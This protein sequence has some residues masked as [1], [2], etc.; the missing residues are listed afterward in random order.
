LGRLLSQVLKV[1]EGFTAHKVSIYSQNFGLE[2]LT[3]QKKLNPAASLVYVLY[4][5]IARMGKEQLRDRVISGLV[6]AK[7]KGK[8]LGRRSG[9]TQSTE[10]IL[11]KHPQAVRRLRE[12]HSLRN[13]CKLAGFPSTLQES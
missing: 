12:G 2:T 10:Q 1:L 7:R 5:E 4:A 9:S 3:P 13:T 8:V 11:A 6:E